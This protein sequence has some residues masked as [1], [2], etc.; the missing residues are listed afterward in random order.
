MFVFYENLIH[1]IFSTDVLILLLFIYLRSVSLKKFN[2]QFTYVGK[3]LCL[4]KETM[5]IKM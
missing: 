2:Y 4:L 1:P 5:T 3:V